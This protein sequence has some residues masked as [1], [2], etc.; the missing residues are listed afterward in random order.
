LNREQ[1]EETNFLIKNSDTQ[2]YNAARK[3]NDH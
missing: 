1:L 3:V 2:L